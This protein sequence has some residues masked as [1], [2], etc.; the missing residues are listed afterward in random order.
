MQAGVVVPVDPFEG[1]ELDGVQA[2]P[3]S[4]TPDQFLLVQLVERFG[5][6]VVV[7]ITDG[8]DRG[9]DACLGKAL[10]VANRDVL[11]SFVG[12]VNELG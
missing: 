6:S 12:M 5:G 1:G 9:L 8:A 3:R 2:A 10:G 4:T 11:T 7:G